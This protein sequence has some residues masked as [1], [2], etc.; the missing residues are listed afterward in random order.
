VLPD[1]PGYSATMHPESLAE[2]AFPHGPAWR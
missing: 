2:F 1:Q